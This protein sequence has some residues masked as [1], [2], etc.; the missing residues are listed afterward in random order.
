MRM[1]KGTLRNVFAGGNKEIINILN[2]KGFAFNS[3]FETSVKYH[4]YDLTYWLSENFNYQAVLL[5]VCIQYFNIDAFISFFQHGSSLNE[6]NLFGCSSVFIASE[7]GSYT[8]V[9]Y[10]FEKGAN[11]DEKNK[12]QT[13]PLHVACSNDSLPIV[14]YLIQKGANI[15]A[16]VY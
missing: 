16:N 10:L 11:I 12:Y 5:P 1:K 6:L 2:S 7:I 9:Q 3:C 15:V 4:R 8:L 14:E 13:T